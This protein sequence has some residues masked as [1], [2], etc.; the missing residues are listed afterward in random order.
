MTVLITLSIAGT[1]SGPYDLYSSPNGVT[2]TSFATGITKS[3]LLAGYTSYVVPDG[4]TVIRILSTGVCTNFIDLMI[5]GGTTTTTT[6]PVPT[7]TTTTT[8][9]V[10]P[11][12]TTTTTPPPTTTTTTTPNPCV[13]YSLDSGGSSAS[14]E[15]DDCNGTYTTL[16]FTGT[17]TICTNGSG[18]SVTI[19]SVTETVPPFSCVS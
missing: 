9:A 19:G 1:D 2:F 5:S 7:T 13:G 10:G 14:I 12:T 11:T 8:P 15:Y 17:T 16:T 4:S 3:A 6:T 18:Y